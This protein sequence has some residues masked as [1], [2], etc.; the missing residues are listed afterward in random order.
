APAESPARAPLRAPQPPALFTSI[1]PILLPIVLIFLNTFSATM[2]ENNEG[3]LPAGLVSTLAFIGNP[4]IALLLGVLVAI[5]G[6]ARNQ[7][8]Q[9]TLDNMEFGVQSAGIILLVTGA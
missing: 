1:L 6:L 2:V 3:A 4:V 9:A 7:S 8:R 5:Y